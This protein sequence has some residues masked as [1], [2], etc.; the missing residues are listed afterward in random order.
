[1]DIPTRRREFE[2]NAKPTA[3]EPRAAPTAIAVWSDFCAVAA[4]PE[5]KRRLREEVATARAQRP[6]LAPLLGLT[7]EPK[8]LG[9]NDGVIIPPESFPLGTRAETVREAAAS[10]APL[11]GAVRVIV[12]LVDYSDKPMV[13]SAAHF[14]DLFFS[15]GVLP[16]GSVKE[17]FAEVTGGL[18]DIVGEVQGPFRLPRTLEWYANENFGTGEPTGQPRANIM[19][20]DAADAADPTVNFGPYDNDGNGF[21]DAFIV[22]HAGSGGEQTGNSGDIWSH[23]WVLPDA[24]ATD[25]TQI[26]AYLTVPEDSRIGVCAHELGHLVFGFPDLYDTDY[27]SEGIGDWCLM[28]GGSWNGGGDIPAHP[29]AW[30][31]ANQAWVE[32]TNLAENRTI[33]IPDVQSSKSVYR[34]WTD[35][36]SGPEY[37]LLENR[38]RTGYDAQLPGEG[39]LIWHID[40]SQIDNTNESHFKVA[41]LQ[42]D[43]QR[44]LEMARDEGDSGD[45]YP[46]ATNNTAFTAS[47]TP[48]SNS[49]SGVSSN[50]SITDIALSGTA[51]TATV[52]NS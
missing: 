48:N 40:E 36:D 17:Y 23:K 42:A 29:S 24:L 46:G 9:F 27:T 14:N 32:V 22:V 12:V 21:V 1:M 15:T 50:V 31:K 39:L 37:F 8:R 4:H 30:C 19:A 34:V 47:S 2:M 10:R 16:N 44:G 13:Q 38:Q 11:Q 41:L 33:T 20:R 18:V 35:G 43:G 45:P 3:T 52:A 49:Y 6:E 26:Y 5:L 7:P 28:A 25:G 51:I